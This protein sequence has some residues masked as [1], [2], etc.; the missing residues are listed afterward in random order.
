MRCVFVVTVVSLTSAIVLAADVK[1]LGVPPGLS[2]AEYDRQGNDLL[3]KG[4]YPAATKYF[5][6]AI[7]LEPDLWTAYYNRAMAY[8]QQNNLKAALQDLNQTIRL[9]P[10]FFLASWMRGGVYTSMHDYRAALRDWDA[11]VRVTAQVQN[12]GELQLML[13][14]RAWLRATCPDASIRNGQLAIADAKRA[15]EITKWRNSQNI[16]TLAAAYAE[17]GD[18]GAA[19]RYEEQAIALSRSGNDE[20]LKSSSKKYAEILAKENTNR[21]KRFGDRLELYKRHQPFRRP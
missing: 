6:A 10:A 1:D 2:A 15:C 13:N 18:F 16:E 17:A 20:Y 12:A 7:R 11:L 21:L 8:L 9:K 3:N 19:V 14:E 5:T 4:N